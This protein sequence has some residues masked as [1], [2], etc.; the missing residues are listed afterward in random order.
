MNAC[1][2][3]GIHSSPGMHA[4]HLHFILIVTVSVKIPVSHNTNWNNSQSI[5]DYVFVF[6]HDVIL[7]KNAIAISFLGYDPVVINAINTI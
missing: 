5:T 2:K 3:R 6:Q 4:D 7:Q 1:I